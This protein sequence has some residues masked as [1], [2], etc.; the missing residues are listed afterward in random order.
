[1]F[2]P[3]PNDGPLEWAL[4]GFASLRRFRHVSEPVSSRNHDV[5]VLMSR[6]PATSA[7]SPPIP[8]YIRKARKNAILFSS[9]EKCGRNASVGQ[10]LC[11]KQGGGFAFATG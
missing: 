7:R 9:Q 5:Q 10:T 3:G 2:R 1:L 6:S 4:G 11:G 8:E